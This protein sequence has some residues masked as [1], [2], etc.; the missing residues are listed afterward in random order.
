M[1]SRSSWVLSRWPM[2]APPG[3]FSPS[4]SRLMIQQSGLECRSNTR[5]FH[6][7]NLADRTRNSDLS[8]VTRVAFDSVDSVIPY[9]VGLVGAGG[10][11]GPFSLIMM[12]SLADRRVAYTER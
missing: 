3:L 7:E 11:A 6:F 5:V 4:I 8:V 10:L 12:R 9:G 2:T 1:G